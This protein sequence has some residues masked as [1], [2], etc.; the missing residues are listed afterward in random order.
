MLGKVPPEVLGAHV[1]DR[2]GA[3]LD[4]VIQGPEYGEDA[5]A[6]DV[7]SGTLVVSSDPL[8]L[9][10]DRVG[11]LGV[12]VACNDVA[13]S[14]GDPTWLTNIIFLP[15]DADDDVLERITT[16]VDEAAAA[17]DVAV[18]GGHSE[19]N[20]TLDRPLL[21]MTCI[22]MADPFVPTGGA[23]PGEVVVLTKGAGIEG[24]AILASDFTTAL[25]EAGI[26]QTVIDEAKG[27]YEDIGV[28][29]DG[30]ILRQY[31]TAM[32]DPTEGGLIDGLLE[33]ANASGVA[34]DIDPGKIP[35]REPTTALT[36]AMDVDPFRI[37]GSGALIGTVPSTTVESVLSELAD[38]GIEAAAIGS[39]TDAPE[40]SLTLGDETFTEPVR[41]DMYRLW[42]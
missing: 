21:T 35:L 39:V 10:A 16:Q 1:F 37:F 38:A 34:L 36:G 32:H 12:N 17:L 6:I 11:T 23:S 30:E 14:G 42:E 13:A 8:S 25:R 19:Y 20:P 27:Y 26:E 22:G 2:E 15:S 4:S 5:A 3:P 28:M 33:L 31:A 24:T 41:D 7:E 29:T 9:A 18:V 40:S